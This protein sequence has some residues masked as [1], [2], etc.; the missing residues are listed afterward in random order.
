MGSQWS[1]C[2]SNNCLLNVEEKSGYI[3]PT[4]DVVLKEDPKRKA[5]RH[6]ASDGE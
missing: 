6:E 3:N 2:D 1:E 4:K 5:Y